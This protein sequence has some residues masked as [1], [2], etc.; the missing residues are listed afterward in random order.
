MAKPKLGLFSK[1]WPVGSVNVMSFTKPTS[2]G[3]REAVVVLDG[4]SEFEPIVRKSIS[5][6]LLTVTV[7]VP[8][9]GG[10]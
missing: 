9:I 1:P 7:A 8:L 10:A 3:S 2:Y 4:A 5:P 6:V